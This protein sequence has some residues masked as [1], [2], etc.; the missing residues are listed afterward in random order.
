MAL[1]VIGTGF[2]RTGTKSLKL[3]LEQLGFGP[4]HHMIEVREKPELLPH[5]EAAARGETPDWDAL[6]TDFRATVDWPA[7]EYWRELTA[8]Y[9]DA[10]VIHTQRPSEAWL[11]S[12]RRTIFPSLKD[13]HDRKE[14]MDR[15]RGDMAHALIVEGTFSGRIDD[16]A[17]CIDVFEAHNAAVREAIPPERL[18]VFEVAEGWGPL[19]AFLDVPVP[20]EPFPHTHTSD[21]FNAKR[22]ARKGG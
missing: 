13:R 10:K 3:V 5:W 17:H 2:G 15:R 1:Q 7:A 11:A 8:H 12:I 14:E 6:F 9:P 22:S 20:D 18:L 21:E 16:D 4:C 19:C